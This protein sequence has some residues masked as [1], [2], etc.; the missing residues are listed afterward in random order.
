MSVWYTATGETIYR[1]S[2]GLSIKTLL[3]KEIQ[4][5]GIIDCISH[6]VGPDKVK[7]KFSW[8]NSMDGIDAAKEIKKFVDEIKRFDP[9]ASVNIDAEIRFVA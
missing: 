3:K 4:P 6:Q 8:N 9:F 7:V 2:S 1:I 5:E